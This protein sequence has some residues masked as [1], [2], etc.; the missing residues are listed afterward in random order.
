MQINNVIKLKTLKLTDQKS[1]QH[2]DA[3]FCILDFLHTQ[4]SAVMYKGSGKNI[5]S[6]YYLGS[7]P[8]PRTIAASMEFSNGSTWQGNSNF[9]VSNTT[10]NVSIP[11][12]INSY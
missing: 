1:I 12:Y 7:S 8:A 2:V 3:N 6:F 4:K 5:K 10:K 11:F 9:T